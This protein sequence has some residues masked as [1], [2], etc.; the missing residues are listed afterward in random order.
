MPQI[1]AVLLIN[2]DY[3]SRLSRENPNNEEAKKDMKDAIGIAIEFEYGR[4]D[5]KLLAGIDKELSQ[6]IPD[7]QG[8]KEEMNQILQKERE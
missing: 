1:P 8:Y 3:R 2:I 7:Y 4:G 5:E 6:K